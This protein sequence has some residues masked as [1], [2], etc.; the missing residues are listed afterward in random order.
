M[1]LRDCDYFRRR[2]DEERL[3]AEQATNDL[4]REVHLELAVR[5]DQAAAVSQEN[6]LR[7][8]MPPVVRG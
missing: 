8:Q 2:T 4:A 6:V 1:A 3:A 5:Y 7:F